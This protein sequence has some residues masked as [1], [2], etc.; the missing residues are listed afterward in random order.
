MMR[1]LENDVLPSCLHAFCRTAIV[2]F[3]GVM[4]IGLNLSA[5]EEVATSASLVRRQSIGPGQGTVSFSK[6][7]D[8]SSSKRPP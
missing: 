1:G 4:A 8:A 2:T 7:L 6:R 3:L 5:A